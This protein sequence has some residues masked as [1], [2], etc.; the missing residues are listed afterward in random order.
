V[1][2]RDELCLLVKEVLSEPHA[3]GAEVGVFKGKTSKMLLAKHSELRLMMVDAYSSE[4]YSF[5]NDPMT[6]QSAADWTHAQKL[7]TRNTAPFAARR[8]MYQVQSMDAALMV[9]D[10]SLDFVFIDADHSYDGV[11]ADSE[12]WWEK[13]RP[14]GMIIWHDYASEAD[15]TKGVKEAVDEFCVGGGLH[16][17]S[18][19]SLA[20]MFKAEESSDGEESPVHVDDDEV[21]EGDAGV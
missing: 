8:N 10:N 3:F 4:A 6:S 21:A 14:G 17:S 1:N 15:H 16:V 9:E 2:Y 19:S 11:R 7:A 12:V 5:G 13:V 18:H 20:W